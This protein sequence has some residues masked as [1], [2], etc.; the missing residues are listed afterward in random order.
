MKNKQLEFTIVGFEILSFSTKKPANTV[1]KDR[2]NFNVQHRFLT[3]SDNHLFHVEINISVISGKQKPDKLS[4]LE[5]R[6]TFKLK[7]IE[8][9]DGMDIPKDLLATFLSIAYSNSRGALTAK[10][11][12]TITGDVPLPL[13]N[14]VAVIDQFVRKHQENEDATT[15]KS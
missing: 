12:G 14:P 11:E 9:D 15:S 1:R 7:S 2:I 3:E 13:I 4:T 8:E 10:S 6:T 5:T